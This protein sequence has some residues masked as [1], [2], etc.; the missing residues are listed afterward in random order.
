MFHA[1]AF[2]KVPNTLL[3]ASFLAGRAGEAQE[4]AERI[5]AKPPAHDLSSDIQRFTFN[6]P[7]PD[8]AKSQRERGSK[9]QSWL[10][11]LAT[12]LDDKPGPAQSRQTSSCQPMQAQSNSA[13][14]DAGG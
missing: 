12:P 1:K 3:V 2:P 6:E 8:E 9:T 11:E 5:S 4:L 7:S 14:D 13:R 10:S